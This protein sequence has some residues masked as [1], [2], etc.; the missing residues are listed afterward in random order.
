MEPQRTTA[1]PPPHIRILTPKIYL[2]ESVWPS[3]GH[4]DTDKIPSNRMCLFRW[5]ERQ[6]TACSNF[7]EAV[8]CHSNHQE[9]SNCKIWCTLWWSGFWHKFLAQW[10]ICCI[11][12]PKLY[13]RSQKNKIEYFCIFGAKSSNLEISKFWTWGSILGCVLKG[14]N[15]WSKVPM[16][17]FHDI[18]GAFRSGE[19]GV[20]TMIF[21]SVFKRL[22]FKIWF[23]S[24][25]VQMRHQANHTKLFDEVKK[26]LVSYI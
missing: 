2:F 3:V 11:L 24:F 4:F 7:E 10:S 20:I 18:G 1:L 26:V 13:S 6:S 16:H 25:C 5:S 17:N 19:S 14:T 15:I 12:G 8:F 23:S 22:K 21:F 9:P